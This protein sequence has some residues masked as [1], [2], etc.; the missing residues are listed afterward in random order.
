MCVPSSASLTTDVDVD[1]L[2]VTA[3]APSQMER[4]APE[5][6]AAFHRYMVELC[7]DRLLQS[8]SLLENF[9][10]MMRTRSSLHDP[11]AAWLPPHHY[12][13]ASAVMRE[14]ATRSTSVRMSG[15]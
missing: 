4:D 10:P 15:C 7:A 1:L 13:V 5:L 3:E 9:L 11:D 14:R 8:T 2:G 6:A 12:P